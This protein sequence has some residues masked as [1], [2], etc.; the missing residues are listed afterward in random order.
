MRKGDEIIGTSATTVLGQLAQYSKGEHEKS[1]PGGSVTFMKDDF[2]MPEDMLHDYLKDLEKQGCIENI[3]WPQ[4]E[5]WA[6]VAIT[7]RG[8]EMLAYV[9]SAD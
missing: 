6:T 1:G 7:D 9:Q 3:D 2:E 5:K 4:D 8:V